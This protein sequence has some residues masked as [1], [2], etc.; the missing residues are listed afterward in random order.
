MFVAWQPYIATQRLCSV[1]FHSFTNTPL[2]LSKTLRHVAWLQV[3]IQFS[4][5]VYTP[6]TWV[7]AEPPSTWWHESDCY[8]LNGNCSGWG[9]LGP[10]RNTWVFNTHLLTMLLT[11]STRVSVIHDRKLSQSKQLYILI[12]QLAMRPDH[13]CKYSWLMMVL[14]LAGCWGMLV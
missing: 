8:H 12:N 10:T 3:S 13:S 14:W 4:V 5:S 1:C 7:I 2:P 11:W 6:L 9:K